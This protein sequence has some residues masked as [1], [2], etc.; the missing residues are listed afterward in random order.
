MTH[1]PKIAVAGTHSTGKT[2]FMK[3]LKRRL[4]DTGL[5]VAY[6]HDSAAEAL[7]AGFPILRNHTFESTAWLIAHAIRLET[8]AALSADVILIDRPVPDAYGYLIA[9]LRTTNRSIDQDRLGCLEAICK[10]WVNEYDL[11]FATKLDVSI[12]VGPGR[13]GDQVFRVA[14]GEAVAEVLAKLAPDHH[15]LTSANLE[16]SIDLAMRI[17][18]HK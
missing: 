8:A 10:A 6:V 12:P 15:V 4:T 18:S 7:A 1:V 17:A 3:D 14:A 11:I 13:D 16:Q 2:T 9:A 5:N